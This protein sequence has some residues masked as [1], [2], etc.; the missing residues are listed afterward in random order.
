MNAAPH[1]SGVLAKDWGAYPHYAYQEADDAALAPIRRVAAIS[2]REK[3]VS[4]TARGVAKP[5]RVEETLD[6]ARLP[7]PEAFWQEVASLPFAADDPEATRVPP[8]A[9]C[10][11]RRAP[12]RW[13]SMKDA[14]RGALAC[15]RAT[16]Q[17]IGEGRWPFPD[18]REV[19]SCRG[20]RRS[21]DRRCWSCRN[22]RSRC[23]RPSAASRP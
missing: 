21:W 14:G 19:L 2:A 15:A 20:P 9:S 8:N 16:A 7:I 23:R 1:A 3:R 4:S 6:W 22:S 13:S 5:E 17:E 11:Q 10:E 12:R 18:P